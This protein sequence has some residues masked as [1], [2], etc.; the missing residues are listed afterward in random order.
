MEQLLNQ[1]KIPEKSVLD[2][3][4]C[5]IHGQWLVMLVNGQSVIAIGGAIIRLF[6][7]GCRLDEGC[8]K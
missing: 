4:W 1:I 5:N 8:G 3:Q 6:A 7:G 2:G